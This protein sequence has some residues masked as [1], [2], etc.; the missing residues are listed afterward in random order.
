MYRI[1]NYLRARLIVG[2]LPNN[3][4][5]GQVED[6]VP[7]M[8][9]LN[10]IINQV[11]AN[12]QAIGL[13]ALL[14]SANSFTQVQSGVPATSAANFPIA[15]QIQNV[16]FNTLSSTLG[17]NTITGRCAALPLSGYAVGQV[18]SFIPSQK[19]T[20][21]ATYAIDGLGSALLKSG[22]QPLVGQ[23]LGSSAVMAVVSSTAGMPVMDL[24]NPQVVSSTWIPSDG[25]GAGL[26][27][28]SVTGYYTKIGRQVTV[29]CT[30][31]FPVTASGASAAVSGLP[32][33]SANI[34]GNIST[35]AA[36]VTAA[37]PAGFGVATLLAGTATVEVRNTSGGNLFTNANLSTGVLH[38][39]LTYFTE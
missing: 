7:V 27:F 24:I 18:F 25:S 39:T 36:F 37:T 12:A 8:A 16:V 11:N 1:R 30:L 29:I 3:I 14:A 19:N 35:G 6:A 10:W 2:T 26:T 9:N 31:T 28:T 4:Q 33:A 17:T 34:A 22:G 20:G 5:N 13:A 32:F 23:E 15:T 21:S 38:F